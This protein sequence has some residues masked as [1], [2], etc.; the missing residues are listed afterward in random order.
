MSIEFDYF[1]GT[2]AEQFAFY[3]IPKLLITSPA[4][5]KVSD[6]AKLLYGLML[7]RSLAITD[8]NVN[9]VVDGL[10]DSLPQK[11]KDVVKNAASLVGKVNYF[12]GGKSSAIGWDSA[13]GTMR[14]VTA[15]GSPSSGSIRAFGLDCSGFVTWA[16]NNSGMGYAVGHGMSV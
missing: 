5:K 16:F 7:D 6:G 13:W 12:W 15:A 8:A 14:R 4:F 11:R 9:A 1:Y 10:P 2:E 3:R